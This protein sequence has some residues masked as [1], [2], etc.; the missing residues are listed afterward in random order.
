MTLD[1]IEFI[2]FTL[3]NQTHDSLKYFV[4]TNENNITCTVVKV[5]Y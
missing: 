5:T 2:K 3:S 1:T 4:T